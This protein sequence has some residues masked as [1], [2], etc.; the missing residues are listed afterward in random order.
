MILRAV[1]DTSRLVTYQAAFYLPGVGGTDHM[2]LVYP[3]RGPSLQATLYHISPVLRMSA[4]KHLLLALKSLY[5]AGFVYQGESICLFYR[6]NT[7][8]CLLADLNI[9]NVM[10]YIDPIDHWTISEIYQHF[11][12][13]RKATLPEARGK[14]GELIE[15]IHVLVDMIGSL[16]YIGDFG[17]SFKYGDTIGSTVQFPLPFC[18]PERLHG[19]APS[20]V[21]DI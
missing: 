18:A 12:R 2:V 19:I 21:S 16:V 20:F 9:G 17:L 15:L 11:S 14:L 1:Q 8:Q 13:P 10:L 6:Q 5:D 7:K 4:A 3:L